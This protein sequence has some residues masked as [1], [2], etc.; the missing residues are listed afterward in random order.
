MGTATDGEHTSPDVIGHSELQV[1][2]HD[3]AD[4]R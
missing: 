1:R 4:D 3:D 2:N